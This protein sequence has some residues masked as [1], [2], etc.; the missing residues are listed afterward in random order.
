MTAFNRIFESH[1]EIFPIFEVIA[2][3]KVIEWQLI[4]QRCQ[5][6]LNYPTI[7]DLVI[8]DVLKN[9][10]KLG[11]THLIETFLSAQVVGFGPKI[12]RPNKIN[13]EALENTNLNITLEEYHQPFSTMVI[14]LPENYSKDRL[15]PCVQAGQ[16]T[17]SNKIIPEKHEPELVV[18]YFDENLKVMIVGIYYN[19]G[20]CVS[21]LIWQKDKTATLQEMIDSFTREHIF[22][23]TLDCSD[24]EMDVAHEAMKVGL[25]CCLL[26]SEFGTKKIGP[27]NSSYYEKCKRNID[28]ARKQGGDRLKSAE[29][30]L[31]LIPIIYDIEQNIELFTEE[32]QKHQEGEPTGIVIKP[33]WRRGHWRRRNILEPSLGKIFIQPILV[34]KHLLKGGEQIKTTYFDK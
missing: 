14:E 12:Y 27:D 25:N 8:K 31:R 17:D 9:V 20:Q 4:D 33:H 13:C 26:M 6:K 23:D 18:I 24:E 30:Q 28:K 16:V 10:E 19:S 22:K 32:K 3:K 11:L 1:R 29:R 34:N 5:I 15:I 2:R 21:T 7:E